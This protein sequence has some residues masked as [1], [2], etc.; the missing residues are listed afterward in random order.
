VVDALDRAGMFAVLHA[1]LPDVVIHQLTDLSG[2]DFA[3][4]ARLRVEGTRNL[5]DASLAV[6]VQRLIAESIAWVYAPGQGPAR[7]EDPLDF[8][9][10]PPR[11]ST[12]AAVHSLERAVAEVPAG[13]ILRY[14]ILYGPGTWYSRDGLT[15]EQV[16]R[17][18]IEAN[19]A[20][21]SFVHVADAA[22]AA[23]LALNWPAGPVNI[24]DDA[25]AAGTDWVPVYA[26]LVG[27]VPPPIKPGALPW[28]RGAS[29][30]RARQLGWNPQYPTWREGFKTALVLASAT[31]ARR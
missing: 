19:D 3:A 30:A 28:E 13:V 2:R 25:P 6:G 1:E 20:V 15:T 21:T 11:R 12:V 4:N 8:D 16:R 10:P 27:A 5:V 14:G 29:N 22:Q 18:E 9:A 17:G 24:V 23:L 26:N 7:E 31:E